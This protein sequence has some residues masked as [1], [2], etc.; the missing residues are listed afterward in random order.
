M[1]KVAAVVL[2]VT[3]TFMVMGMALAAVKGKKVVS[4][5]PTLTDSQKQALSSNAL[6][7]L[8][9]QSWTI[10]ITPQGAPY[11]KPEVDVLTFTETTLSSKDL[12]AR[13]YGTSSISMVV[14]NDG[15]VIWQ[16]VQRNKVAG[17]TASWRGEMSGNGMYGIMS[18]K[19]K[20]SSRQNYEFS[21]SAPPVPPAVS[22]GAKK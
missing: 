3:V 22:P 15:M 2:A 12:I 11:S 4:A 17:T 9:G 21:T 5:P 13:G 19:L 18:I 8:H 7:K 10:Y 6:S 14:Q 1:R 16:T 20:D